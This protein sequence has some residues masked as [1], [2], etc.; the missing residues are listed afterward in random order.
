MILFLSL[1]SASSISSPLLSSIFLSSP[2]F[3]IYVII[4]IHILYTIIYIQQIFTGNSITNVMI[5]ER[6][7]KKTRTNYVYACKKKIIF[8]LIL[9]YIRKYASIYTHLYICMCVSVCMYI[10][11]IYI[12]SFFCRH[13]RSREI[14]R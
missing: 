13:D 11:Y 1:C 12:I 10:Y 8:S 7:K 5:N 9:T 6:K 2:L 14:C 3:R 4:Y